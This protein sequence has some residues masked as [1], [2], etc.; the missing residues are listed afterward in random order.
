MA[1]SNVK[2]MHAARPA[3]MTRKMTVGGKRV[4]VK[5]VATFEVFQGKDRLTGRSRRTMTASARYKPAL[6]YFHIVAGNGEI[7][8]QSEGYTRR[9]T[10][11]QGAKRVLAAQ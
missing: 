3:G 11:V 9:F 7:I 6:W 10:A 4:T 5:R 1:Q 2:W 8:A